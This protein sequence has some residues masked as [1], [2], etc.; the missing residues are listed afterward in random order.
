MTSQSGVM[1]RRK[2]DKAMIRASSLQRIAT[3]FTFLEGPV[4]CPP[5]TPAAGLCG[6][7][8]GGLIFSD[9]GAGRI[10]SY[11]EGRITI[12]REPSRRANG[13]ALDTRGCLV[14]C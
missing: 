13:N 7:P 8:G 4:W 9:L 1:E 2:T 10:Y 12:C 5:R 11:S 6:M 3:G 14:T